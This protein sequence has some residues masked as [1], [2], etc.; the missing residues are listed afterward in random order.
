MLPK[1]KSQNQG[2]MRARSGQS[3]WGGEGGG[4]ALAGVVRMPHRSWDLTK[5]AAPW[6]RVRTSGQDRQ[7][8][9]PQHHLGEG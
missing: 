5:E 8:W 9:Q 6:R 4:T 7:A 3:G 1:E 2:S